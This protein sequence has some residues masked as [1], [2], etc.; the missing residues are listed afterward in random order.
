MKDVVIV[1]GVRTPVGAFGG[2]LKSPAIMNPA[3]ASR[4][5]TTRNTITL[6]KIS[7]AV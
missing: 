3:A 5:M 4:L 1:S 7:A 6:K 2:S